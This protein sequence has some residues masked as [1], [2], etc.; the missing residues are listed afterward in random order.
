[1][2][3][4]PLFID[5]QGAVVLIIGHSESTDEKIAKLLP[6]QPKIR[7]FVENTFDK[8]VSPQVEVLRRVFLPEDLS[9]SPA[10]VLIAQADPDEKASLF[11]LCCE[12]HIPVNTVDEPDLCTFYFPALITCGAC[13]IGVSTSGLSPSAAGLIR[14]QIEDVLPD[15]IDEILDWSHDIRLQIRRITSSPQKRRLIMKQI[16]AAAFEKNRP[17]SEQ[18]L[19]D[20][21][22]A[23][24]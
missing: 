15:R 3:C 8:A 2:R 13:S 18:E 10:F 23:T 12:R 20:I 19:Q 11:R 7:L 16:T 22:S 5:L 4:F 21:F 1:M 9:P 14:R 6:Y 24:E 17:L